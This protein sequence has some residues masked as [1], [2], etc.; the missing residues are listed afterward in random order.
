MLHPLVHQVK[1]IKYNSDYRI[2]DIIYKRGY[3][4]KHSLEKVKK[5]EKYKD[6]ILQNYLINN[7]N[8]ELDHTLFL[9]CINSFNNNR[10][11]KISNPID[12]EIV[13]HLRLGDVVTEKKRFLQKDYISLIK[14]IINKNKK[15]NKL[16]IV[17]SYQYSPFSE[18]CLHLA[19]KKDIWMYSDGKQNKNKN[20]LSDLIKLIEKNFEF[21]IKIYSNTNID[22]DLLYCVFAKH[23]ITDIGG[24]DKLIKTLNKNF[25]ENKFYKNN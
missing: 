6:S 18:D 12:T 5:E 7:S 3:R 2:G 9:S 20:S 1:T 25:L 24:F 23:L 8:Y 14:K 19:P 15:I 11:A 17:T 21:K 10:N 13:M 4:W 16:T 22:E